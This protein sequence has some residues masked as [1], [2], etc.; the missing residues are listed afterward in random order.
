MSPIQGM[1]AGGVD[2]SQE[3]SDCSD[4]I[5]FLT[6]L[7]LEHLI[8][9]FEREQITFEILA[10]MGHEELKAVG[11]CAYGY[12]HKII[13]AVAAAKASS[14]FA[15]DANISTMLIDLG[16]SDKEYLMVED[17][18]QSTIRQHQKDNGNMGGIL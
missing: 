16:S 4:V 7:K 15:A 8:D 9:L 3:R 2:A 5:S 12:R 10:E 11:V 13:K 18:M 17:E 1:E 6:K 14:G